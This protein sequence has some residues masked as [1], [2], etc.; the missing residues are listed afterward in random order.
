MDRRVA[1]VVLDEPDHM[2]RGRGFETGRFE[3]DAVGAAPPER[4][5][6]PDARQFG[7]VAHLFGRC[8]ELGAERARE[9]LVRGVP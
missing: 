4:F 5:D 6:H 9:S 1:V 2:H 3:R 7:A 8:A